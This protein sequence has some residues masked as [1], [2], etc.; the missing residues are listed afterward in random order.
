M[1]IKNFLV[2]IC[3]LLSVSLSYS[4]TKTKSNGKTKAPSDTNNVDKAGK[5]QGPWN[6][7]NKNKGGC[8]KVGQRTE[9][10]VYKDDKKTG[11]W[12]EF[13]C[14]GA[15]KNTINYTNGVKEGQIKSYYDNGKIKEEGTWKNGH[16][17]GRYVSYKED[18]TEKEIMYDEKGKEIVKK[19]SDSEGGGLKKK[20]WD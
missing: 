11:L 13:H 19:E 7:L 5:K 4:Q 6:I 14:N 8:Y 15:I 9:T 17:V 10:G 20:Y 2:I 1:E 16:W 18:G 12:T 3:C